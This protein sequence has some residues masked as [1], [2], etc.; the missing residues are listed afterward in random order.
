[1]GGNDGNHKMMGAGIFPEIKSHRRFFCDTGAGIPNMKYIYI[2]WKDDINDTWITS[3]MYK[4]LPF[5]GCFAG[6]RA[7]LFTHKRKIQVFQI[8]KWYTYCWWPFNPTYISWEVVIPP[9]K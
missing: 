6:K 5:G 8:S 1:M 7:H 4:N 9:L 2:F 3:D